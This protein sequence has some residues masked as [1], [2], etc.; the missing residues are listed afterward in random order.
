MAILLPW[1]SPLT[2]AGIS[3][4]PLLDDLAQKSTS[5]G[6][7]SK[8]MVPERLSGSEVLGRSFSCAA[9]AGLSTHLGLEGHRSALS[10]W[11]QVVSLEKTL[12][13]GNIEGK[14]RRG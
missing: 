7:A 2:S 11:L 4:K 1:S 14:R 10:K 13:L 9:S 8:A 12:L 3:Q 6:S 5:P